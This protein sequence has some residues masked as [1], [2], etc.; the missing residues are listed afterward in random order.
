[1]KKLLAV[2]LV[3]ALPVLAANTRS[4]F[5][6]FIVTGDIADTPTQFVTTNL[7]VRT[8]TILG[9]VSAR[10]NNA[11]TVYIG[12]TSTQN[13]QAYPVTAGGTVTITAFPG[14]EFNLREWYMESP[15]GVG[16]NIIVIYQ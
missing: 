10:V 9:K 15:A 14:T 6:Q 12:P 11:A 3:L 7:W 5:A 4:S 2:L 16:N 8:V 1:M 13:E